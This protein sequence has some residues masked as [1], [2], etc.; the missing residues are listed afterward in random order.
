MSIE[1]GGH[2]RPPEKYLKII[3]GG[4][5]GTEGVFLPDFIKN[6]STFYKIKSRK[7]EPTLANMC[8]KSQ[9]A[10]W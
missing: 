4:Q 10:R 2:K 1:G 5:E 9:H 8:R 6:Q 3:K 7:E